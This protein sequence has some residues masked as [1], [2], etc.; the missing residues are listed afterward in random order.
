[1]L[2][3]SRIRGLGLHN[4]SPR[5]VGRKPRGLPTPVEVPWEA[6]WVQRISPRAVGVFPGWGAGQ[7][8]GSGRW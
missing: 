4:L 2:V 1:M 8:A 5:F 6:S 3:F 7:S